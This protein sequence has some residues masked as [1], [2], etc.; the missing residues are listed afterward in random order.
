MTGMNLREKQQFISEI[1]CFMNTIRSIEEDSIKNG[2]CKDYNEF[3]EIF[4]EIVEPN[5]QDKTT[6]NH[7]RTMYAH[8]Y[9]MKVAIE[10]QARAH[11]ATLNKKKILSLK[12]YKK[13][14]VG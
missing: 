5:I 4:G 7:L 3:R 1:E 9:Y 6:I 11:V 2:Y 13:K 10:N 8:Y 14:L 12:D